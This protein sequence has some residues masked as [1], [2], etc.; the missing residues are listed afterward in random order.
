MPVASPPFLGHPSRPT[1]PAALCV[2]AVLVAL[3]PAPSPLWASLLR[4]GCSVF[5]FA[6]VRF[7]LLSPL[8]GFFVLRVSPSFFLPLSLLSRFSLFLVLPLLWRAICWFLPSFFAPWCWLPLAPPSRHPLPCWWPVLSFRVGSPSPR[9]APLP[10]PAFFSVAVPLPWFSAPPPF[11]LRFRVSAAPSPL[12]R[13]PLC[14]VVF[15]LPSLPSL[16]SIGV[17]AWL[18]PTLSAGLSAL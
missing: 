7:C 1:S 9:C 5:L 11:P 3:A 16:S 8:V 2:Y 18:L 4:C 10:A 12:R 14:V 6:F 15:G 17:P 13:V